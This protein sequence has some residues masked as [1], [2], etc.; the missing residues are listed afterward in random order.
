MADATWTPQETIYA[1]KD[2]NIVAADDPKR[3]R[4]LAQAGQPMQRDRAV[5]LGLIEVSEPDVVV[6]AATKDAAA[7][8]ETKDVKGPSGRKAR[9][10]E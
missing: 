6:K 3:S 9:D 2:G 1:D 8:P 4:V 7:A 5:A 10:T